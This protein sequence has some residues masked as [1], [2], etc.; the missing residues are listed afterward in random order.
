MESAI[1]KVRSFLRKA[2]NKEYLQ[3]KL[4]PHHQ[5]KENQLR[6]LFNRIMVRPLECL[7]NLEEGEDF[8]FLFWA[9][10]SGMIKSDFAKR[11]ELENED[12]LVL[13][14]LYL[15]EIINNYYRAKAFKRKER[16]MA[17]NDLDL[18]L[19][20]PPYAYSIDSIIKFTNSKGVPLLGLYS[21]S[22]LQSW[23][24]SKLTNHQDEALPDLLLITGPMDAK[25]YIKKENY[26]PFSFKLLLDSRPIVKKAVSDRW[27]AIIKDYQSESAMEKDEDFERLLKRYT[28]ELAPELEA[29]LADKKLFLACDEMEQTQGLL[30]DNARFYSREGALLP[31]SILFLVNRKDVLTDIR[32]ILPFWYSI[33]LLISFISFLQKMKNIKFEREKKK[34]KLGGPKRTAPVEKSRAKEILEAGRKLETEIV[35]PD[36]DLD[37]CLAQLESR[38]NTLLKKQ[39]REDL[40]TDVQS[41][42]RDRLRQTLRGQRHVML[43]KDSLDNLARRMVEENP[44]LRDLRS[45]DYLRQYVVLYMVKLL[46]QTTF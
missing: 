42:V 10:F 17:F 29:V 34:A 2:D 33:P 7:S 38:W 24:Q 25:R 37:N 12:F 21:D 1:L 44:T 35:P 13:Q 22:D 36:N 6:D 32:A 20:Q 4:I 46:V 27:L 23:L 41:L 19:S 18:L 26:Y 3:N 31:P 40:L 11:N 45:Q 14:S 28:G 39:A 16:D 30:P 43:T 5:G 9:S 8:S 15:I